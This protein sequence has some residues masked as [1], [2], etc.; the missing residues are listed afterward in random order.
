MSEKSGLS[1]SY[2]NEIEKG[3]KYPKPEKITKLADA[4]ETTYE[5]MVSLK[6]EKKLALLG[7]IIQSNILNEL[8]LE[9]FG[10]DSNKILTILSEAPK[11]VNAFLST[12]LELSRNTELRN[13]HFYHTA[14]RSYQELNFNYFIDL[15]KLAV[16][17]RKEKDGSMMKEGEIKNVLQSKYGYNFQELDLAQY[18]EL[19]SIRSVLYPKK[20]N[21][22]LINP[23]LS[24]AQ[25]RFIFARELSFNLLDVKVRPLTFS[26][27]RI[28]SFDELHNNFRASYLSVSLLIDEARF[29][30]DIKDFFQTKKFDSKRIDKLLTKYQVTPE[31]L[32]HRLTSILPKFFGIRSLFF[33]RFN[34]PR[35]EDYFSLSKEL[36]LSKK[37]NPHGN[38]LGEHYCRRWVALGVL[39]ELNKNQKSGKGNK[40]VIRA[41]VSKYLGSENEY[42][43]I[44]IARHMGPTPNVNSS[45]T[46]GLLVNKDLRKKVVFLND[47]SI[48]IREVNST[49]ER[50]PAENCKDRVAESFV[51]NNIN[52]KEKVKGALSNL[53]SSL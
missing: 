32:L 29:K 36:H 15:E 13:E 39:K 19:I 43:C 25:R 44:S 28:R 37:H 53:E 48:K 24:L 12:L 16:E 51:I 27:N 35:Q 49:C 46:L 11:K 41:Q 52:A 5:E 42:L 38:R 3:K 22:L 8:P 17:Y 20:G 10:V 18:P 1:V 4:L 33:L 26:Y 47:L 14:L 40:L 6:L 30:D 9:F 31:M 7:D 21:L 2:L 45:V 50:C 34:N 23:N